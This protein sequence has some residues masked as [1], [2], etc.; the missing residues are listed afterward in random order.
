MK[1]F[2]TALVVAW[3]ATLWVSVRA[4]LAMGA[5]SAGDVFFGDLGHPWRAQF[6]VDFSIHL[7][8]MASWIAYREKSPVRGIPIGLAAILFGGA[9]SF[10]YIFIATFTAGGDARRLLLGSRA[11][12]GA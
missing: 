3:V 2:R 9:F 6:N 11:A 1:V 12:V 5:G 4:I 8:L 10:A 7:L